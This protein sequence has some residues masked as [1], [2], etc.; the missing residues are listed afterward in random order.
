MCTPTTLEVLRQRLTQPKLNKPKVL[1]STH[2]F[3]RPPV[4]MATVT[5]HN[6]Y[7]EMQNEIKL[8]AGAYIRAYRPWHSL[9]NVRLRLETNTGDGV[10][11]CSFGQYLF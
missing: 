9:Y 6:S 1:N 8:S 5:L 3:Q 2:T 11:S 4:A 10:S 7:R